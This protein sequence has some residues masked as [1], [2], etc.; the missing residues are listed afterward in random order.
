MNGNLFKKHVFSYTIFPEIL[1]VPGR[2]DSGQGL[3]PCGKIEGIGRSHL[4][5]N[6]LK[7]K[8][9]A[10]QKR[11]CLLNPLPFPKPTRR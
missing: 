3:E 8:I 10:F 1:P 6:L 9:R 4:P 11:F 2:G 5:G 7:R